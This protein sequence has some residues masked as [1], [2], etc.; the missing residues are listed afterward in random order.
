[1]AVNYCGICFITLAPGFVIADEEDMS[2]RCE[3]PVHQVLE[4]I[5]AELYV[6][7]QQQ[8]ISLKKSSKMMS[9]P[10]WDRAYITFYGL[11][12]HNKLGC[13]SREY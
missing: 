8:W 1:M 4:A 12:L 10:F 3:S 6:Q 5:P 9:L 13:S 2:G 7:D 11:N